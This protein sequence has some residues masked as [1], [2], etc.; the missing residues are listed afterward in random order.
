MV[1]QMENVSDGSD[2]GSPVKVTGWYDNERGFS[3]RTLD[4]VELISQK[5]VH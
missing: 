1:E 4:L 2:R 3:G 5:E